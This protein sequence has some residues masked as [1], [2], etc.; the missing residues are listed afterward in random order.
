MR[1][2]TSLVLKAYRLMLAC[3]PAAFRAEFSPE[4][5]AVF[6]T[7]LCEAQRHGHILDATM[8]RTARL[9]WLSVTGTP[10]RKDEQDGDSS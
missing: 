4:M 6:Y 7:K 5:Y 8:A 9:A 3:Y 1:T 10:T 2:H